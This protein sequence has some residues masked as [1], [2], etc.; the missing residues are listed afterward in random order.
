M[1]AAQKII[2]HWPEM[3]LLPPPGRPVLVRVDTSPSR[4]AA[5]QELR[6]VLRQILAVWSGF[7]PEPLPL[8]A[9]ARGP[10]WS[11]LLGGQTLDIS[12]SYAEGG[13]WIGLIRAGLIGVDAMKVQPVPEAE[14]LARHYLG[15][16]ALAAIQQSNDPA[17][18][19]AVAWTEL[20][21]RLKC[22][23]YEL[24]ERPIAPAVA[25]TECAIQRMV[26]PDR[27]IVTVATAPIRP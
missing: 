27:L 4:P 6:N 21:A 17:M 19:F 18:A 24:S 20:E 8:C 14:E 9:T 16:A 2:F 11:G 3:P 5:R 7:L 13:G 12:L 10:V 1:N 22:L 23:K 26:L 15:H 25:T